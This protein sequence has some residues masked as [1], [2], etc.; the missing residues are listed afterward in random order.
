MIAGPHR[1]RVYLDSNVFIYAVEGRTE[2]SEPLRGLFNA[3]Q[4]R[5][6]FAVTSELTIAEVLAKATPT[7]QRDYIDL[8]VESDLFDLCTVTRGILIAT[9]S[10]RQAFGMAK[11][12]DAIHVMTAVHSS[13]G[14]MLSADRRLR[15]PEGLR[16]LDST[17][18][19]VS[20]LI[21]ELA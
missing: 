4:R 15:P 7:Q 14:T 13:C 20:R 11:L 19:N 18:E 10:Y 21:E 8:I 9:A 16:M 17:R 5:P 2:I 6:G 3:F 12:A 1:S